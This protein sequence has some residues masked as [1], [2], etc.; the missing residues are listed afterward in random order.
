MTDAKYPINFTQSRKRFA[1]ILPY[2]GST[3]F[4]FVNANKLCQ[5]KEEDSKTKDYA[6]CLGNIQKF[7]QLIIW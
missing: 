2:N 6:L 7:L 1:L 3:S 5:F 4:L